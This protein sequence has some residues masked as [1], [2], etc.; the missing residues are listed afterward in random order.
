MFDVGQN[1]RKL[2]VTTTAFVA[3]KSKR[4]VRKRE[5]GMHLMVVPVNVDQIEARKSMKKMLKK[6]SFNRGQK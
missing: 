5:G 1:D 6:T 3:H 2:R 4:T